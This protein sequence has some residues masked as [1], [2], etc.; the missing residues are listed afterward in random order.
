MACAGYLEGDKEARAAIHKVVRNGTGDRHGDYPQELCPRVRCRGRRIGRHR[1][2]RKRGGCCRRRGR[3]NGSPRLRRHRAPNLGPR[4]RGPGARLG[5]RRLL[6]PRRGL[7]PRG[8]RARREL[9]RL[10]HRLLVHAQRRLDLRRGLA[11]PEG[12]R[13]RRLGGPLRR[14][15]PPRRR[16]RRRPR[17]HPRLGRD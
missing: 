13:H 5:H 10:G 6:R 12:R 11:H 1:L 3:C 2:P 4:V 16:R 9:G 17:H 15:H 14:R 8:R 7:R